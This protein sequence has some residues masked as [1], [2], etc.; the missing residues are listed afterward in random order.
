MAAREVFQGGTCPLTSGAMKAETLENR[1]AG[2]SCYRADAKAS[3][4][5][6][7]I[8]NS[9]AGEDLSAPMRVAY[10]I[11]LGHINGIMLTSSFP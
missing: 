1:P 7:R 6:C 5:H 4:P 8:G 9:N 2:M 10:I 11:D 3:A